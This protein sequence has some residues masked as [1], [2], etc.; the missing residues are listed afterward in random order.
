MSNILGKIAAPVSNLVGSIV[1]TI[2]N[3]N[4]QE[5]ENK[6]NKEMAE[7]QYS[8]DLEMWNR[9]N[10]YNT[11]QSQM[12]RFSAAGLNKNLI[13][14]QG[15]S[16]NAT[17]LPK[18]S[19]PTIKERTRMPDLQGMI[20]A[21]QDFQLKKAQV[22]QTTEQ[23]KLIQE[24]AATEAVNRAWMGLKFGK[25]EYTWHGGMNDQGNMFYAGDKNFYHDEQK[26]KRYISTQKQ[27]T[28]LG[29]GTLANYNW[30][31]AKQKLQ[32]LEKDNQYYFWKNVGS[33]AARGATN[34]FTRGLARKGGKIAKMVGKP[35]LPTNTMKGYKNNMDILPNYNF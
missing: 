16:G 27:N 6:A 33:G 13:Y 32:I 12:E 23:T 29:M 8:K 4:A 28:A 2:G 7:Y 24:K 14:G 25:D 18:Y 9:Q 20:P 35:K 10:E 22:D 15:S 5:R 11:P 17:T 3:K 30:Q 26:K 21:Y 19:A 34:L 31:I 1:T